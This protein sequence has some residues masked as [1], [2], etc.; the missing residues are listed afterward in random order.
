MKNKKHDKNDEQK[1]P[2]FVAPRMFDNGRI[3]ALTAGPTGP[4][5]EAA[6]QRCIESVVRLVPRD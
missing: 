2:R 1:A 6:D 3:A 5:E 4:E